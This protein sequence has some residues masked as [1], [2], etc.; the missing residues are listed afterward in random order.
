MLIIDPATG[1]MYNLAPNKVDQKLT[2]E[3][4]GQPH[5]SDELV[6][7]TTAQATASQLQAM[8]P[9]KPIG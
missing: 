6:V 3:T 9:I 2:P 7:I 5:Q 1:A 4:A 8:E